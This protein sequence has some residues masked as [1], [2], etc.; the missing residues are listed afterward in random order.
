MQAR[1]PCWEHPSAAFLLLK[2][3]LSVCSGASCGHALPWLLSDPQGSAGL[4]EPWRLSRSPECRPHCRALPTSAGRVLG[5]GARVWK[6]VTPDPEFSGLYPLFWSWVASGYEEGWEAELR[7]GV[8]TPLNLEP[9]Q[10]TG[11]WASQLNFT[12][13]FPSLGSQSLKT[14][15]LESTSN[16]FFVLMWAGHVIPPLSV[17]PC[18]EVPGL[19]VWPLEGPVRL[20]PGSPSV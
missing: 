13:S 12:V 19:C 11:G 2:A 18:P 5:W 14:T 7:V 3:G 15:Y 17:R 4:L 8:S 1:P 20:W 6:P 10:R 9:Q 16:V